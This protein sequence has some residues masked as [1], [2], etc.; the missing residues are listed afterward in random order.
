MQAKLLRCRRIFFIWLFSV[1][2][3][4]IGSVHAQILTLA[5]LPYQNPQ[6]LDSLLALDESR[7]ASTITNNWPLVDRTL[8]RYI[9]AG[10]S[11][12]QPSFFS[13]VTARSAPALVKR[14]P[15][16]SIWI[17]WLS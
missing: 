10:V 2:L 8:A 16:A 13:A 5:Q 12:D 17:F 9:P 14:L 7:F 4:A 3:F 6:A 11:I 15:V 1:P